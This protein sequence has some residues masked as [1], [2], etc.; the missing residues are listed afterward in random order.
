MELYYEK[1]LDLTC[2]ATCQSNF[3]S[4]LSCIDKRAIHSSTETNERCLMDCLLPKKGITD[5]VLCIE[6]CNEKQNKSLSLI[7]NDA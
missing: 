6:Q 3:E 1:A 2:E 7:L 4:M 5:Q